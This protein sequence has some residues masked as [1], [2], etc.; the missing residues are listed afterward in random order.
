MG[1]ENQFVGRIS[2]FFGVI[3]LLTDTKESSIVELKQFSKHRKLRGY[4]FFLCG[5]K[6]S[7]PIGSLLMNSEKDL[8]LGLKR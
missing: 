2:L 4:F 6:I 1:F 3:Y 5:K 7:H 8:C